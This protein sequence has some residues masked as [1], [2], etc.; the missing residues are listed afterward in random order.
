MI[1][2][3]VYAAL[4]YANFREYKRSTLVDLIDEI[5][6]IL[7]TV[8]VLESLYFCH[9]HPPVWRT[10]V[11]A[12]QMADSIVWKRFVKW[13][14][15][16]PDTTLFDIDGNISLQK[17]TSKW[18]SHLNTKDVLRWQPTRLI[19]VLICMRH[20]RRVN[21]YYKTLTSLCHFTKQCNEYRDII[22]GTITS[23][24]KSSCFFCD[25]N[26]SQIIYIIWNC[27]STFHFLVLPLLLKFFCI[28]R[29]MHIVRDI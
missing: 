28:Y 13:L 6:G 12:V 29:V 17:Y 4:N 23:L 7:A 9:H 22:R 1:L 10:I 27:Y 2:L 24:L 5:Y 20:V 25:N 14:I 21:C 16:A 8:V 19:D 26:M 15:F 18:R 3:W 11:M